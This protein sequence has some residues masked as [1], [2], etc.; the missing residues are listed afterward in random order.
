MNPTIL[1]EMIN[2]SKIYQHLNSRGRS[3]FWP[4][5]VFAGYL[6]SNS[7]YGIY[8]TSITGECHSNK[9]DNEAKQ[10]CITALNELHSYDV[11]HRDIRFSNF[12]I[13]DNYRL[14]LLFNY[15]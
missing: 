7:Y 14:W 2:E 5:L 10:K 15:K 4:T 8:T 6:F 13:N 3:D 11:L 9:F 12:I 1:N